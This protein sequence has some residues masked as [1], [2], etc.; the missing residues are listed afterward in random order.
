MS[1][2]Q[3]SVRRPAILNEGGRIKGW[4][5]NNIVTYSGSVSRWKFFTLTVQ[6]TTLDYSSHTLTV[7]YTTLD[8][9]SQLF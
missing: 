5:E 9:S 2:V 1:R 8:Y 6:Y 4:Y 7:Q 3:I